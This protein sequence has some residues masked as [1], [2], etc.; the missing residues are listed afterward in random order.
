MIVRFG[1]RH[2]KTGVNQA[3]D[4]LAENK[5]IDREFSVKQCQLRGP[6]RSC[7]LV[8]FSP[9]RRLMA[10]THGDHNIYVTEVKTGTCVQTL[11]GHPRTP[12]CIAFHPSFSD[13]IASGCLGGQVRVWDLHCGSELWVTDGVIASLAFHPVERLLVIATFNELHFWDWSQSKPLVKIVTSNDRER[14]RYVKFD[15]VGHQ[16]ITG[17]ANLTPLQSAAAAAAA[18]EANEDLASDLLRARDADER[19]Y[20][21]ILDRFE[22]AFDRINRDLEWPET[23]ARRVLDQPELIQVLTNHRSV[24]LT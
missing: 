20:N 10:S 5:L 12:W 23:G 13:I 3:I 2:C 21:V 24:F 1:S 18:R 22:R 9:D 11:K 14:V 7:F 6:T 8:V 16:L 19:R 15:K 17:I 4:E